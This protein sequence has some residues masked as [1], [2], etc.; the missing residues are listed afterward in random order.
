M[1]YFSFQ[2]GRGGEERTIRS[3]LLIGFV[4]SGWIAR[5]HASHLRLLEGV[6]IGPHF[7]TS[8]ESSRLFARQT[9]SNPAETEDA[10]IDGC[11]LVFICTPPH[12]HLDTIG[13]C[14]ERNR[15]FFCEKPLAGSLEEG[16]RIAALVAGGEGAFAFIGFNFRFFGAWLKCRE[17]IRQGRIGTPLQFSIQRI[18]Q[19]PAGGWRKDPSALCGMTIESVSHDIDL[20]MWIFGEVESVSAHAAAADSSLPGFD[21][22]L[23]ALVRMECGVHGSISCSWASTVDVAPSHTVIGTKGAITIE[24]PRPWDF[25]TLRFREHG[26]EE[27]TFHFTELAER[28]H[29]GICRHVVDVMRGKDENRIPLE[30]GLRALRVCAAM[31]GPGGPGRQ[32]RTRGV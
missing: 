14:V 21:D 10:V 20:M 15:A 7:D 16:E 3:S 2:V 31:I 22:T 23:S 6:C 4:G 30:D 19:G 27:E 17:L 1:V 28:R 32:N 5:Q 26:G 11:D 13:T 8:P 9:G 29:Q 24:S 25:S 18:H 12:C